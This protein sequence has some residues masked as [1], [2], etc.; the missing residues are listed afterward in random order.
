MRITLCPLTRWLPSSGNWV[1]TVWS[2]EVFPPHPHPAQFDSKAGGT[3]LRQRVADQGLAFSGLAADLWSF[4]IIPQ[5]DNSAL[6]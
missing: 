3:E 4:P 1:L 2:W 6:A 5:D